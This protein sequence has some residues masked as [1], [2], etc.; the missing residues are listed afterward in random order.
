[1]RIRGIAWLAPAV[2]LIGPFR[3]GICQ[4]GPDAALYESFFRQVAEAA[5]RT[6][7]VP[8]RVSPATVLN[9]APTT[10]RQPTAQETLSLTDQEARALNTVAADCETKIRSYDHAVGPSLLAARIE[11]LGS[12]SAA[13]AQVLKDLTSARNA[14]VLAHV[15]ELKAALGDSRFQTV[16]SYVRSKK[17]GESFLPLVP[18][19]K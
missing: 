3:P 13:A 4:S 19:D 1:M 14:V 17:N 9:G 12:Q 2:L 7:P 5:D 15:S 16:D 8:V 6:G 18:I 11:L 10:L